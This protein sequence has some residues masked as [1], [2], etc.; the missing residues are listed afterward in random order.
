MIEEEKLKE[1][2]KETYLEIANGY[3]ISD[4][5]HDSDKVACV[6]SRFRSMVLKKLN[7]ISN[8]K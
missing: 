8:D 2:L 6:A 7:I 3:D 1:V 4:L 5:H